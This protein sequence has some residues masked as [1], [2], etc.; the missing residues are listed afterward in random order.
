[1]IFGFGCVFLFFVK[2]DLSMEKGGHAHFHNSKAKS[3]LP[4]NRPN[5]LAR[6]AELFR[7]L[8][9]WNNNNNIFFSFFGLG[10]AFLEFTLALYKGAK[11][12]LVV[13]VMVLVARVVVLLLLLLLVVVVVAL[14]LVGLWLWL[15]LL[16]LLL[17]LLLLFFG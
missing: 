6:G 11:V 12:M 9:A 16:L 1:M 5:P 10:A 8:F 14:L 3:Y 15:W 4:K 7:D 2:N 17:L 13:L